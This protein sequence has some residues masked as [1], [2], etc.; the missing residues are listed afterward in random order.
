VFSDVHGDSW[1]LDVSK[2]ENLIT[3]KTK[4]IIVVHLYGMPANMFELMKF[5]RAHNLYV[6]EDAAEAMFAKNGDAFVGSL[7]DIATFSLFGNKV[8][9]SGEGGIL[10]TNN[11]ELA[12]K[13]ELLK[14]QGMDPNRRYWFP[15]IGF[16]Y[17]MTNVAAA[18]FCAQFSRR[19][20]LV[21]SRWKIYEIYDSFFADN[22]GITIQKDA[23]G[24]TRSPWLYPLLVEGISRQQRDELI[25]TLDSEGVE[26]RPFFIPVHTMPPYKAFPPRNSL[27]NTERL[28]STGFNLPTFPDLD[29]RQ[30]SQVAELVLKTISKIR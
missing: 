15:I 13:V 1:C 27:E 28:S 25:S 29:H 24:I 22:E 18:I 6:I 10:V 30:V 21:E 17:R 8:L 4:A 7:G 11:T 14:G 5:A 12:S 19:E 20:F 2:I 3:P 23:I 16:N 26:T 9:S